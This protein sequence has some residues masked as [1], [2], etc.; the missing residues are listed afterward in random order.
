MNI[1]GK[2]KE[3]SGK[4]GPTCIPN[5]LFHTVPTKTTTQTA[6][7][8]SQS[9]VGLVK[10]LGKKTKYAIAWRAWLCEMQLQHQEG[11][12]KHKKL[13]CNKIVKALK[14]RKCHYDLESSLLSPRSHPLLQRNGVPFPSV[15]RTHCHIGPCTRTY[16]TKP[17]GLSLCQWQISKGNELWFISLEVFVLYSL[18]STPLALKWLQQEATSETRSQ[19]WYSWPISPRLPS[20]SILLCHIYRGKPH[21]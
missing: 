3:N 10:L 18:H 16:P 13:K 1:S 8:Q 11:F 9:P 5:T 4:L 7:H 21:N 6:G 2:Q 17:M 20:D 12:I 15:S 14:M 19:K